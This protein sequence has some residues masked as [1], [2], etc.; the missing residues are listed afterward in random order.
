MKEKGQKQC[1][2]KTGSRK[3]RILDKLVGEG[4][5]SMEKREKR[6]V[7]KTVYCRNQLY[8]TDQD[9]WG[10]YKRIVVYLECAGTRLEQIEVY[11]NG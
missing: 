5:T 11:N 6:I 4:W 7:I 8:C 2:K 3:S 9:Y 1:Y 10:K